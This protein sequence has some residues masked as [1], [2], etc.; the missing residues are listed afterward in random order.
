[1]NLIQL[2]NQSPYTFFY[3]IVDNY[4]AFPLQ[5]I[6]KNFY[7]IYSHRSPRIDY[8]KK[9]KLPYFCLEEQG[10]NISKNSGLLLSQPSVINFISSHTPAK[11]QSVVIPFKPSAK[12]EN[13]AHRYRWLIAANP[14][15]L[16]RQLEDKIKFFNL[17]QQHQLP[18]ISS[19][20]DNFTQANF[21]KYQRLYGSKLVLQTHFGWAGKSTF[22]SDS[23]SSLNLQISPDTL[24]KYSPFV[25]GYTLLNNCCLTSQGLIQSPPALQYTGIP[26]LTS[27][28]FT[29]VGRQWPSFAP[30]KVVNEVYKIS[31][32]F[33][34][35]LEDRQ[36]RGFFGLDFLVDDHNQVLLLEC[37]P[38]LTASTAFYTDLE[39]KNSLTPLFFFHLLEFLNLHFPFDIK[40]E[41]GRFFNSQIQGSEITPKDKTG[42]TIKKIHLDY[43]L[44]KTTNLTDVSFSSI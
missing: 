2:I 17:C 23:Y 18:V 8:L 22:I 12:I 32:L 7:P 25:S 3:P 13:I 9:K 14:S 27:N 26:N 42:S 41:K 34:S 10:I 44:S 16:N 43:P 21:L 36:Y 6:I 1:M 4:L 19:T 33:S 40:K 31:E 20:I 30:Q 29:T 5:G 38:R 15:Y 37:N 39:L 11:H 35:L 24:V 28:P